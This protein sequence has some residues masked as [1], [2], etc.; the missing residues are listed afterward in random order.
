MIVTFERSASRLSACVGMPSY[1]TVPSVGMQR[2]RDSV[3]VDLPE[4]VRPTVFGEV[5]KSQR[6]SSQPALSKNRHATLTD[7]DAFAR[8]DAEADVFQHGRSVLV[9]EKW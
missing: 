9:N 7:A 2:S 5:P 1:T 8:V 4:P 3:N 6:A